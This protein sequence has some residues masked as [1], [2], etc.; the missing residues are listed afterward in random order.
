[1][2]R[3]EII[4]ANPLEI[5]VRN[6]GYV[7]KRAGQGFV[8]SGCSVEEH[9]KLGHHP[10]TINVQK[11]LWH[12]ND[13]DKGG[14]VIDWVMH[15]RGC[16]AA[17]AIQ[18]LGGSRNGEVSRV[19]SR[20]RG[21][22]HATK[23]FDWQKCVAAFT[24]DE[25]EELTEWRGFSGSFVARLH[26]YKL[27]GMHDGLVATPVHDHG[28]VV[29]AHYRLPDGTWRYTPKGITSE[30]LV[31][32]DLSTATEV[33]AF[34]SQWDAFAGC[35][36]LG[37]HERKDVAVIITRGASNGARVADLVPK[38]ATI[39]VWPQNDDAGKKWEC[40]IGARINVRSV[41]TAAP[42]KDLNAWTRDGGA[43]RQD[44]LHAIANAET[45]RAP[46]KAPEREPRI[47]FYTPF[48]LRDYVPDKDIVLVGD[49]NIMRGE[50]FVL[51]GEPGVGKSLAATQ[52][53]VSGATQRDWFGLIVHRQFRTMIVQTENGRYRLRQEFST[54]D[55]DEIEGWIR[56]SEPP[57]FGLTLTNAEFQEDVRAALDSFEPECVIFD[58]WNAAA[59]DDKVREYSETFDALRS[60]LPTGSDKPALGIVAHTRK[61]APNEKRTGGSGLMHL[62]AGSYILTSVPRCIFVMTRGSQDET[63]D[64]VVFFNPKNSNGAN[65]S[66]S[67]WHRKLSGFT[68]ATDF[69]WKDFDK[70][71]EERKITRLE[72]VR[73][74]FGNGEKRLEKKEA[75][76]LLAALAKVNDT[77]AYR[78]L[79]KFAGYIQEDKK[80]V[81]CFREP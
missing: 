1:M 33:H 4:A 64:S 59:R 67:A 71:P 9:K 8:T 81:L 65:V 18:L 80:R 41:R 69:D 49:C 36:K 26:E 51:G 42:F 2:T 44:L 24:Q 13:C 70:R 57:P 15:E 63:D 31:I 25:R 46:E 58:P 19:A 53:A 50:V 7:L 40:H 55:C 52:L 77:S 3:A 16:T 30:P 73:E 20:Y 76:R 56:V 28:N 6:R 11:Q 43:R 22:R 21:V 48:E 34:E 38:D 61:P 62:L 72:H 27:I 32:G 60:L 23:G 17:E 39:Y 29:G 74:V 47:Q 78:A 45:L 5:F 12:C 75:A 68:R 66:R 14:T 79:R 10:V 37:W 54:L 35:D